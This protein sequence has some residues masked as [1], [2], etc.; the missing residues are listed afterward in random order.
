MRV[1]TDMK[2]DGTYTEYY[3]GVNFNPADY[4]LDKVRFQVR[5][6]LIVAVIKE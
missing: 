4:D 5:S 3:H 1:A 2:S 6:G